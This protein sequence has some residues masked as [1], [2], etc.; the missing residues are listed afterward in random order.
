MVPHP[1]EPVPP[2]HPRRLLSDVRDVRAGAKHLKH[3]HLKMALEVD[4][5]GAAEVRDKLP[6]EMMLAD[7]PSAGCPR[8]RGRH[9]CAARK[10]RLSHAKYPRDMR[11]KTVPKPERD[12]KPPVW[13]LYLPERAYDAACVRSRSGVQ[14]ALPPRNEAA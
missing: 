5:A 3:L 1:P 6:G 13:G 8:R 2:G 9:D 10:M 4:D 12:D 14:H 11:N 7:D